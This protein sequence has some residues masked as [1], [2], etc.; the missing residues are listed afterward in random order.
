[1]PRASSLFCLP[2][3]LALAASAHAIELPVIINGDQVAQNKAQPTTSPASANSPAPIIINFPSAAFV[4]GNPKSNVPLP[5]IANQTP[6]ANAGTAAPARA[7]NAYAV[8]VN[9]GYVTPVGYN[10][11]GF[12]SGF[13]A[14]GGGWG[15]NMYAPYAGGLGYYGGLGYGGLGYG[16]LGYGGL[17]FSGLGYGGFGGYGNGGYAAPLPVAPWGLSWLPPRVEVLDSGVRANAGR[18]TTMPGVAAPVFGDVIG[19]YYR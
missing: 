7:P 14:Y 19:V 15:A 8:W 16:G 13:G 11:Y 3:V 17:G 5:T 1:M 6:A 2:A 10:A 9:N 12:G 4:G 18:L